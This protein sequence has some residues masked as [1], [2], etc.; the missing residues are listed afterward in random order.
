MRIGIV[1]GGQLARMLALAG[2]PL[3]MRFTFLDPAA[4]AGAA[5]LG[6]HIV[7]AYDDPAALDALADASDVVTYEFENVPADGMQ[8]LLDRVPVYPHPRA[9]AASRDRASEKQLFRDLAIPVPPYVLVDAETD[10]RRAVAELGLPA[11]LKTRTLG[12]DGKGQAVLRTAD[13]VAA[14]WERLGGVP[15]ILES[16][17]TFTREISMVA[18]RGRDGATAFYPVSENVHRDGIL[19]IS[20]CRR[21]DPA[22]TTAQ[23]YAARLL[24]HLDYVGVLALELFDTPQGLYANEMAPRVH[25]SGHWTIEGACTSQFENHVR[26]VCGLPLGDTAPLGCTA[27]L[28]CIGKLPDIDAV[29]KHADVHVHDYDKQPRAGR[30]VGHITV[31]SDAASALE[32]LVQAITQVLPE[33]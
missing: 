29:L 33:N 1:G 24:A 4:D 21:E 8:R 17:V 19:R 15:L 5:A 31:R 12:Y 18:A 20:R 7:G 23:E 14:A 10:L 25:N 32:D 16:F 27:M 13:D 28:N 9:L 2:I 22:A 30:K 26:A 6:R 11:V 3:G